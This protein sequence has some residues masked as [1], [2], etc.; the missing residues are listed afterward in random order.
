MRRFR[1]N[2]VDPDHN[3]CTITHNSASSKGSPGKLALPR[4]PGGNWIGC[5][6]FAAQYPGS[7]FFEHSPDIY[8]PAPCPPYGGL[9]PRMLMTHT[10]VP[11][12]GCVH[13]SP[14]P[15]MVMDVA[16]PFPVPCPRQAS[17]PFSGMVR[18]PSYPAK[19]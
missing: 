15:A 3:T 13:W 16:A 17:P 2:T 6:R 5:L 19:I 8:R 4:R 12:S 9:P 10:P 18:M 1:R 11:I 14:G 7:V